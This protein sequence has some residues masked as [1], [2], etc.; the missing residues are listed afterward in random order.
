LKSVGCYIPCRNDAVN[1]SKCLNALLNQTL[2]P[3]QIVV[4]NDGSDKEVNAL[5]QSFNFES[6]NLSAHKKSYVGSPLMAKIHNVGLEILDQIDSYDYILVLGADHILPS[7][8]LEDL[9]FKTFHDGSVISSGIIEGEKSR[10]PR[11][12]GRLIDYDFFKNELGLRYPV[13]YGF[14]TWLIYQALSLGYHY[15]VYPQ[16]TSTTLRRSSV[17][18]RGYE[19]YALGYNWKYA[20]GRCFFLFF[21][22]PIVG[23]QTFYDWILHKDVDRYDLAGWVNEYQHDL[24]W[25]RIKNV[26]F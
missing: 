1:L 6:V 14:E 15:T 10:E 25:E 18:S 24:F 9:V 12:S 20:L 23:F 22:N 7:N 8:Y 13:N 21:N 3:K 16:L 11:G 2:L 26:D 4:V 5:T 19:M 17:I